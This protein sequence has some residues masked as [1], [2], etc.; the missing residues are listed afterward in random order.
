M[1]SAMRRPQLQT[2]AST[3]ALAAHSTVLVSK[4]KRVSRAKAQRRKGKDAKR[5][6]IILLCVFLCAF[7]SLRES[8]TPSLAF[9]L[10]SLCTHAVFLFPEFGSELRTEILG[11]KDLTNLDLGVALSS[12]RIKRNALHPLDCLLERVHFPDPETGNEFSRFGE[13]TIGDNPV[14][15]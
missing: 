11:F 14:T 13:W 9:Q 15:A 12:F 1:T 2:A 6:V 3:S 10:R 5:N 7:A 8:L 4:A